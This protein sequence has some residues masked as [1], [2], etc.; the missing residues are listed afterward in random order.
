I[1]DADA[2]VLRIG[3]IGDLCR[4][5]GLRPQHDAAA[6]I[7]LRGVRIALAGLDDLIDEHLVRRRVKEE[8]RALLDLLREQTARA[9]VEV[10]RD[11]GLLRERL[12]ELRES[13]REV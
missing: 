7:E 6:R 8:R 11:A 10:R 3:E 13:L 4:R 5:P 2:L 1:R 9:E 12:A